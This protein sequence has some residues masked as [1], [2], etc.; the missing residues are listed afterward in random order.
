MEEVR[1]DK[2]GKQRKEMKDE[3][4]RIR[5]R[6]KRDKG[7]VDRRNEI[8]YTENERKEGR[9]EISNQRSSKR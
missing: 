1:D 8:N 5:K 9:L 4:S 7:R 2:K 3:V 6:K